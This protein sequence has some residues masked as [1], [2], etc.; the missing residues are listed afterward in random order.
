MV[1]IIQRFLLFI[2]RNKSTYYTKQA[3][4]HL[5]F[6]RKSNGDNGPP[7]FM[8]ITLA[9]GEHWTPVHER[10][11]ISETAGSRAT[12]IK[13]TS[14]KRRGFVPRGPPSSSGPSGS[15]RSRAKDVSIFAVTMS[16]R[17]NIRL[18][19]RCFVNLSKELLINDIGQIFLFNILC[20]R[21]YLKKNNR[22]I[23]LYKWK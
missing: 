2:F 6:T 18:T 11:S 8:R 3:W 5:S 1:N 16:L 9:R 22:D 21:Q 17:R 14:L 10:W 12:S 23:N 7:D 20:T 4:T 13:C 19:C 15:F